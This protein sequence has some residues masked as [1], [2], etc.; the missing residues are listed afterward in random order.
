[1]KFLV[2]ILSALL[3]ASC[4]DQNSSSTEVELEAI[5]KELENITEELEND[6]SEFSQDYNFDGVPDVYFEKSEFSY[7]QFIDRNFDGAPD[8]RYEYDSGTDFIIDGRLDENFDGEFETQL[9][10]NQ[11]VVQYKF[12]D[13]NSDRLIDVVESYEHGV[14]KKV[15]IFMPKSYEHTSS[16][17]TLFFNFGVPYSEEIA[18]TALTLKTFHESQV[19]K[20][21][22]QNMVPN[23]TGT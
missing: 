23:A 15:S 10:I 6:A 13:S 19:K 16:I 9:V 20:I 17:K 4:S 2:I 8:E 3:T 7:F 22:V 14:L 1:M 21:P 11:G 18:E 12:T 5:L